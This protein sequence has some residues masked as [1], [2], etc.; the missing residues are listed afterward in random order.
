MHEA[1]E[2]PRVSMMDDLQEE[3]EQLIT[4]KAKQLIKVENEFKEKYE[5]LEAMLMDMVQ[6]AK[7]LKEDMDTNKL[8]ASGI[9]AEG[10]LRFALSVESL[11]G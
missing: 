9:E 2:S 8:T 1:G 11:I 7:L 3:L 6:E 5:Y 4:K 10:Y